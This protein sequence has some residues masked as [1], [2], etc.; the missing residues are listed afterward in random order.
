MPRPNNPDEGIKTTF[1]Y[2]KGDYPKA[3]YTPT[4]Y[5]ARWTEDGTKEISK[6]IL[7]FGGFG[8]LNRPRNPFRL[9]FHAGRATNLRADIFVTQIAEWQNNTMVEI[10][11]NKQTTRGTFPLYWFRYHWDQPD[12]HILTL[13]QKEAAKQTI[14]NW[15]SMRNK[16]SQ[17]VLCYLKNEV[18]D[19]LTVS[20]ANFLILFVTMPEWKSFL[21]IGEYDFRPF[22]EYLYKLRITCNETSTDTLFYKLSIRSWNDYTFTFLGNYSDVDASL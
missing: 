12:L 2:Q 7:K 19:E 9:V 3:E 8:V 1:A 20:R 10:P 11:K 5:I 15:K 13:D 17:L 21:S 4:Y 18:L 14:E 16:P 22:G 6:L